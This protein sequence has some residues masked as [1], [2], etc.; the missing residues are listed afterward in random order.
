M[1]DHFANDEGK[2][3]LR[4]IGSRSASSASR[5]S[6][7]IWCFSRF[8]SDGGKPCVAFSSPTA[9]VQRK[10]SASVWIRIASKLS[11]DGVGP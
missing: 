11:I 4:E 6:L 1:A 7:S 2:E 10:R 8:G 5:R 3:F 9:F